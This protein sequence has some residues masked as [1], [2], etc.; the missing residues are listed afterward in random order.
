MRADSTAFGVCTSGWIVPPRDATRKASGGGITIST[1][2]RT[3]W[4]RAATERK[5]RDEW[6]VLRRRI[7]V[8]RPGSEA[9]QDHRVAFARDF[10]GAVTEMPSLPGSVVDG[11]N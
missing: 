11:D 8:A 6:S 5:V 3:S 2:I 7:K 4:A 9:V 1:R 10:A